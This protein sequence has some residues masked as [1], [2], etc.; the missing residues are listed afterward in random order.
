MN[1]IVK[2]FFNNGALRNYMIKN[3]WNPNISV[4]VCRVSNGQV[5]IH[6]KGNQLFSNLMDAQIVFPDLD[7]SKHTKR[8]TSAMGDPKKDVMR[9]ETWEAES[10][11]G[12]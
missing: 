7:P 6:G 8:F 5:T 1:Y 2:C 10:L 11:Y 9:F 4:L 3:V 12:S